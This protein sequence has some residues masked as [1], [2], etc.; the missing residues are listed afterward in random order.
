MKRPRNASEWTSVV[1]F[2]ILA[3]GVVLAV[4]YLRP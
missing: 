3:A 2:V 1:F 4:L